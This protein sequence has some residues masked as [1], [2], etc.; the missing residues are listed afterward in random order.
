M[1]IAFNV[2]NN[3]D[4]NDENHIDRYDTNTE[5]NS[6]D[7][8]VKPS[9][10][11]VERSLGYDAAAAT[12]QSLSN[13]KDKTLLD[14]TAATMAAIMMDDDETSTTDDELKHRGGNEGKKDGRESFH[15]S[16]KDRDTKKKRKKTKNQSDDSTDFTGG[17]DVV[18]VAAGR[19]DEYDDREDSFVDVT[20]DGRVVVLPDASN[21]ENVRE[22]IRDT[23]IREEKESNT[24]SANMADATT[25]K[26]SAE[27]ADGTTS[28]KRK[29]DAQSRKLEQDS[30]QGEVGGEKEDVAYNP[31][32]LL[33][34]NYSSI[35]SSGVVMTHYM[36]LPLDSTI[37]DAMMKSTKTSEVITKSLPFLE[38]LMVSV[39]NQQVQEYCDPFYR[40]LAMAIADLD[41]ITVSLISSSAGGTNMNEKEEKAILSVQVKYM[42]DGLCDGCHLEGNATVGLLLSPTSSTADERVSPTADLHHHLRSA[43]PVSSQQQCPCTT[44]NPN[45]RAPN[46]HEYLRAM[47][48]VLQDK[49]NGT[50]GTLG[51]QS[52]GQLKEISGKEEV[53]HEVPCSSER[54]EFYTSVLSNLQLDRDA[55]TVQEIALLQ[56]AFRDI[57]NQLAFSLCDKKFRN[58]TL[59]QG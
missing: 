28:T 3:K 15:P 7:Q 20:A 36:E 58:S 31:T 26:K 57:Y 32:T 22:H 34:S 59:S 29:I 13:K 46:S 35:F 21:M 18:V 9:K 45:S 42:V 39:Y 23:Y 40:R 50:S 33:C 56:D 30:A 55:V 8:V 12:G 17:D 5:K 37:T 48:Q 1:V 51:I 25:K 43:S 14:K 44:V 27:T 54:N 52:I 41:S 4:E 53:T 16:N 19:V 11:D 24:A 47:N 2:D 6:E 38:D 10:K 49:W